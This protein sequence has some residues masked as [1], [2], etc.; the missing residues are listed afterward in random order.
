MTSFLF[1]NL[2]RKPLQDMV[3]SLALHYEVDVLMLV[4]C[5]IEP[6]VLL[7][8]LNRDDGADYSYALGVSRGKAEIYTRF[9]CEFL[10]PKQD[11]DR[12]TI[13]HLRLPGRSDILLAV[14][15]YPSKMHWSDADQASQCGPLLAQP[16]QLAEDDVGHRRTLLVGD[17][18]MNPFEHGMVEASGLH[19]VMTRRI[20]ERRA[21]IVQ[22]REYPFFY[23]PM[24]GL[25]GDA[26]PGPPGTYYN[27]RP[28]P[29]EYFWHMFDQV[30]IRPDLL[31]L[32]RNE[33]LEIVTS[34]GSTSL[35][36]RN[37]LPDGT[38]ASDHLPL[39][40]RLAL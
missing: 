40:F 5:S 18:N 17:L 20:A 33:D 39:F 3:A 8:T 24:W 1:W 6:G 31:P 12:L 38:V 16:I 28:K 25:F 26:S 29:R 10:R 37:Q 21:R 30:L 22:G 13:R 36:T 35:L 9:P 15:H 27:R 11:Q 19:A 34:D 32:F 4:E 2:N 23:N 7:R 14:T